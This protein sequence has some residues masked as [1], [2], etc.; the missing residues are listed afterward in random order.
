MREVFDR[1]ADEGEFDTVVNLE[2]G[3][4][5]GALD[6]TDEFADEAFLLELGGEFFVEED[7]EARAFGEFL[8]LVGD[9]FDVYFLGDDLPV[10]IVEPIIEAGDV[11]EAGERLADFDL[12]EFVATIHAEGEAAFDYFAGEGHFIIDV[13][14]GFAGL[15]PIL[16]VHATL[17]Y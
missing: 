3:G 17:A 12:A 6:E 1:V 15:G 16:E 4:F 14:V 10:E 11:S 9:F 7:F 13:C 2:V 8:L 5:A